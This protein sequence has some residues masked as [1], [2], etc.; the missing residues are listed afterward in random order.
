MWT[1]PSPP[2]I[3]LFYLWGTEADESCFAGWRVHLSDDVCFYLATGRQHKRKRC[4]VA[5]G[6]H[7]DTIP[8]EHGGLLAFFY[9]QT[10]SSADETSRARR[11]SLEQ[12]L[13]PRGI[14]RKGSVCWVTGG[15]WWQY[16]KSTLDWRSGCRPREQRWILASLVSLAG[17][18]SVR[19]VRGRT[20]L[21]A[22]GFFFFCL[23]SVLWKNNKSLQRLE[24]HL[25]SDWSESFIFI[26]FIIFFLAIA[27]V[28]LTV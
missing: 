4:V 22:Q 12:Q 9:F 14:Q 15:K 11:L 27:Q 21:S 25:Y 10:C 3:S 7:R 6:Q 2:R 16:P 5:R 28:L 23:T 26:Y 8:P 13:I 24:K 20:P 18:R 17:S 1:N 19:S